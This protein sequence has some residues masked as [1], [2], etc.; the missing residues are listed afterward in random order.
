MRKVIYTIYV[1]I[2]NE[3]PSAR[4]ANQTIVTEHAFIVAERLIGDGQAAFEI[5]R[6][7]ESVHYEVIEE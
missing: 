4:D 6:N 1:S 5:K 7:D 2:E 3:H